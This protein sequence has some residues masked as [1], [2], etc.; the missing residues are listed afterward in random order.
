VEGVFVLSSNLTVLLVDSAQK[1]R[2]TSIRR[3]HWLIEAS[4]RHK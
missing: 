4:C 1:T 2:N 3:Y